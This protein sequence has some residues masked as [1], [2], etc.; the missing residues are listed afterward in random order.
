MTKNE[1][2][3]H[4]KSNLKYVIIGAVSL[5]IIS[6]ILIFALDSLK[7]TLKYSLPTVFLTWLAVFG[8]SHVDLIDTVIEYP[9]WAAT[10][11]FL[12][13]AILRVLIAVLPLFRLLKMPPARLANKFDF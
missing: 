10:I 12:G 5:V 9:L 6:L 1:L 3:S 11:T 7:T 4:R 13:I 2:P 8:I